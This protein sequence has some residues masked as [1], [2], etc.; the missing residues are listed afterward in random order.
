ML[1]INLPLLGIT[2]II[3]LSLIVVLNS[4]LYK[5]LL[6]FIDNRNL[7]IRADEESVSK[8]TSDVGAYKIEVEK[9]IADARNQ[10]AEIRNQAI[11]KAK[12]NAAQ[13]LSNA[14]SNLEGEYAVF[15]QNLENSKAELKSE[16]LAKMPEFKDSLRATLSKI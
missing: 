8:N 2:T 1:E 4:L 7:S 14:R 5:P 6:N 3:F 13:N 11:A 9:I 12:E 16:L 15:K 10:A